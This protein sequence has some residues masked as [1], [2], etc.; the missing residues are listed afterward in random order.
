M[1]LISLVKK[2]HSRRKIK[3]RTSAQFVSNMQTKIV[4]NV[5]LSNIAPLTVSVKI[6]L[7]TKL[8]VPNCKTMTNSMSLS[9]V[10]G[11]KISFNLKMD[12]LFHK[13]NKVS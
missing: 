9:K 8:S 1:L 12:K 11:E 6:G 4:A 7:I 5:N 13:L 10:V 3:N 2:C